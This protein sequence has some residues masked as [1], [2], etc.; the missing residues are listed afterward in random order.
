MD[1]KSNEVWE[2]Q[3]SGQYWK[4]ENEGDYITGEVKEINTGTYG[5]VYTIENKKDG[6]NY[7]TPNY[8]VL[9]SRM[10][11]VRVGDIVRIVFI[12]DELPS[13]KGHNPTKI[14]EVYKKKEIMEEKV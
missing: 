5:K 1:K 4:P 11:R 6:E 7:L 12:R 14:F 9:E 10:I 13:V 3:E 8:K 2:R